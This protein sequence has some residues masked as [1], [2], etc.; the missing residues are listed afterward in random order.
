[1]QKY[2]IGAA[3]KMLCVLAYAITGDHAQNVYNMGVGKPP[4]T[5]GNNVFVYAASHYIFYGNL[6]DPRE[7]D[8]ESS[9]FCLLVEDRM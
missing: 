3:Q 5:R 2:E 9:F 1:M 6:C 8:S 4:S 7:E